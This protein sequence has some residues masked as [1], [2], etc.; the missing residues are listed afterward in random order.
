MSDIRA[1]LITLPESH[2]G[3]ETKELQLLPAHLTSATAC[4]GGRCARELAGRIF[5]Y[6]MDPSEET[7]CN[8]SLGLVRCGSKPPVY[9]N[10]QRWMKIDK[11]FKGIFEY[12]FFLK[13][14]SFL[15]CIMHI[16]GR[17]AWH[18]GQWDNPN[19][20]WSSHQAAT[21]FIILVY[22]SIWGHVCVCGKQKEL[23]ACTPNVWWRSCF[24]TCTK[25]YKLDFFIQW[26]WW[27][28]IQ[29]ST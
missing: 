1:V 19:Q 6:R 20:L 24:P 3:G 25:R 15:I 13:K 11:E 28:E 5:S 23:M 16:H 2:T 10:G 8:C 17:T 27:D 9:R 18:K 21:A 22:F 29:Q 26:S 14:P 4:H 7:G 12:V